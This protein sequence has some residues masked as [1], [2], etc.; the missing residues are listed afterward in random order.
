MELL[1]SSQELPGILNYS[2]RYGYIGIFLFFITIDQLTPFPEEIT[3]LTIGYLSSN[4]VVN[5]ILVGIAS[6]AAF[7]TVD[8]VYFFWARSG[9]KFIEKMLAG[10]KNSMMNKFKK[11]FNDSFGI[12]LID[13]CFIPRMRLFVQSLQG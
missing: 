6:I 5:P 13:L 10:K 7:L 12:S 9:N 11:K 4:H 3:L 1:I 2:S 8:L